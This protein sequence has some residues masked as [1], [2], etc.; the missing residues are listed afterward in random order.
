MTIKEH[1]NAAALQG[2]KRPMRLPH[3]LRRQ[4]EILDAA[5][6]YGGPQHHVLSDV[7]CLIIA[8]YTKNEWHD[9][10]SV[11][12]TYFAALEDSLSQEGGHLELDFERT[13]SSYLE[14]LSADDVVLLKAGYDRAA[15]D[16]TAELEHAERLHDERRPVLVP[17]G[18]V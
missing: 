17:Q 2:A 5:Q 12:Q 13:F 3:F 8:H 6:V 11:A 16:Y 4:D 7:S 9:F 14:H 10:E 18:L 1:A 15:Q